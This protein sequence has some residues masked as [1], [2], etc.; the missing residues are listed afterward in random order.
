[1]GVDKETIK[2]K[3]K[4]F[5]AENYILTSNDAISDDDSFLETGI[6]DSTGVLELV[7][8]LETT[9]EMKVE[10]EELT[11]ENLDSINKVVDFVC[12]KTAASV[13]AAAA[14]GDA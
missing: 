5:V 3:T 7:A 10:N 9:F 1:M 13:E 2:Q 6:I 4:A 12:V 14:K 11:T 8:F